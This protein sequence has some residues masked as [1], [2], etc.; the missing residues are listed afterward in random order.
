MHF[1]SGDDAR[2]EGISPEKDV[3][4]E[5]ASPHPRSASQLTAKTVSTKQVIDAQASNSSAV[6]ASSH[7]SRQGSAKKSETT[8]GQCRCV[9]PT[10]TVSTRVNLVSLSLVSLTL[11]MVMLC[12]VSGNQQKS[13]SFMSTHSET[14]GAHSPDAAQ[15]A[16]S[17][18]SMAQ[19]DG[20]EET[21]SEGTDAYTDLSNLVIAAAE[22]TRITFASCLRWS[23]F[24]TA[25]LLF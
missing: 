6:A 10:H 12:C 2:D 22:T 24:V 25:A 9:G 19:S 4:S 15:P 13:M 8:V 16:K 18:L 1:A 3:E 14:A 17:S 23:V 7:S 5:N 11:T 20:A 21:R